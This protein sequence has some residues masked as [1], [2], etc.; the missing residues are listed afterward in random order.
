MKASGF[1]Y[2]ALRSPDPLRIG[3][4]YADLFECGFFIHPILSGL[5]VVIVKIANPES[6]LRGI[7]EFW[8]LDIH[9]E[10]ATASLLRIP[11]RQRPNPKS[12]RLSRGQREGG[13]P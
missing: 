7:L 10:G 3:K 12:C 8:P 11:R 9:W 6:V 5:R 13:D 2:C 4:F 1:L